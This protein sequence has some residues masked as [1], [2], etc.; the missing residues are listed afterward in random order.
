VR[1]SCGAEPPECPWNAWS[2][3]EVKAVVNAWQWFDKGQLSALLG[4][5]PPAWILD[6]VRTFAAA[7][8]AARAD[9]QDQERRARELTHGR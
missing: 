2:D 1:Q 3:P 4:E 6:G 5:D 8:D 7:L 9:V